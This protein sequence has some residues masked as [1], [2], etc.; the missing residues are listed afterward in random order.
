MEQ[1]HN[2][3]A[4]PETL[5]TQS[6]HFSRIASC[7][8]AVFPLT[9]AVG[10]LFRVPV[11][12]Q[13]FPS[14]PAMNPNTSAGLLLGAVAVFWTS[15][16]RKERRHDGAG[17]MLAALILV[18][19]LL[20][21]GQYVFSVDLGID[22]A[23]FPGRP[24]AGQPFPGR[25]SPQSSASFVLFGAALLLYRA[26]STG[27]LG[28][29]CALLAGSNAVVALTGYIF[30]TSEFYGFPPF[31]VA[32][33]MSVLTALGFILLSIALVGAHPDVGM[34]TLV[35][36]QTSSGGMAR[37]ILAV[38]VVAPPV[39]GLLTRIGVILNWYSTGV[40]IALFAV[41][42]LGLVLVATWI[43]ARRAERE[44]LRAKAIFDER[45][46]LA[47]L[48]EN[49]SDFIGVANPNGKAVYV[50]P[51]GRRMVGLD[52]DYPIE[53]TSILEFYPS[54]QRSFAAN[55]IVKSMVEQGY[56]KGETYFRNWKTEASIPVSD[57]HFMIRER[58]TGRV[59]GMGTVTRDITEVNRIR[60]QV[61][62]SER[63]FRTLTE[64]MPQ[65]VWITRPDGWNI[66][67]N[68]HWVDYTGMSLEESYGHGWNVPFHPDD[69]QRAWEA[70]QNAVRTDG[71]YS[72]ECRL[73]RRDG[74]YRWW[75]TRGVSLHD[76][77]G[78]ITNWFSTYTDIDDLRRTKEELAELN[79]SLE[80][81]VAERTAQLTK[82]VEQR[83]ESE[84]IYR[85]I[86]ESIDYGVWICDPTGRN[87]Y[88][89]ESFL[90][91]V[92]MTQDECSHFGWGRVLHPDDAERTLAAWKECVR[93]RGK[94]DIQHRFIGADGKWHPILAR[95]VHVENEHGEIICWAGI[96]LD[97]SKL[98]E[99][100]DALRLHGEALQR[101]E[102]KF[103]RMFESN[104][105]GL[106]LWNEHGEVV[107]ANE[108]Y[109]NTIGYTRDDLKAGRIDWRK[110][111]PTEW[112][113]V[114][115]KELMA[116]KRDRV[117]PSYEKEY[118]KKDGSK[119]PIVVAAAMLDGIPGVDGIGYTLEIGE[120]K[121][122]E[123]ERDRI[124]VALAEANEQLERRVRDRTLDLMKSNKELEQFAYIASHDLQT[125]LR[126]IASYVQLLIG[127]VKKTT[128]LDPQ[129]EK[130]IMYILNG[131]QQ[132]KS[133]IS[134]LLT[135]SR[136]GRVDVAVEEIK[137]ATVIE[138][139]SEVLQ[140]SIRK[141][142]AKISYS[143]LP[144]V[145]GIRS[146][147][148]QLFQN[149]IENAIKFQKPDVAPVVEI[150][151]EDQGEFWKFYVSDNG[152]GIDPKYVERI[153]AMFQRLHTREEYAGT[154]IGLAVCKKIVEFH[155]GKI[156]VE[157]A[158][159]KGS[160]F[161]FS[162]PKKERA[163]EPVI[164]RESKRNWW[165]RAGSN[166][167]PAGYESAALTI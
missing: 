59:L 25:S 23:L 156:G 61:Q 95:G 2:V 93:T 150:R 120:R 139:V 9:A 142:E 134:D 47:A 20:S 7:V 129:T 71:V 51:A 8:A 55:V 30:S 32:T 34:M 104:L 64:A 4:M 109:L 133:L 3:P 119:I 18:L 141:T 108:A 166:C 165:L 89:S 60:D 145:F 26:T 151:C 144:V 116:L 62:E 127:K 22:R 90:K 157:S 163:E 103:R 138:E 101:S 92:G 122:L 19:G 52:S 131:T 81:K 159:G 45:L 70:W 53:N 27:R 73:R 48:I 148:N 63:N 6:R 57:E 88:A 31:E 114:D 16:D 83:K 11:L 98:K 85:A 125:P 94:W 126:H 82:E 58:E 49:S 161:F 68:Q 137:V 66:Y 33:G 162:L 130:W 39:I 128:D 56:W 113:E 75:L 107:E 50:N 152:I 132:M 37:R 123:R 105:I 28:Q 118:V 36:S 102:L 100:E 40:Q 106:F 43:A 69:Q 84:R 77:N 1:L 29:V 153:F 149:L 67:F 44:E 65:I 13:V 87:T 167:R 158:E 24:I 143:V 164:K 147:L 76:A 160:N 5:M 79:Q 21:L 10:W 35:T 12:T 155:G 112:S 91:L 41:L 121:R 74:A 111:T 72:L 54:A 78:K 17:F 117:I 38:S 110:I 15:A 136:V 140:E 135:Y 46:V 86:G 124:T 80:R 115:A 154:G 14:L 42:L 96:N 146:Q 99:S 97:I